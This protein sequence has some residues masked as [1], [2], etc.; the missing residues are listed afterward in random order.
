MLTAFLESRPCL[1]EAVKKKKKKKRN[2]YR[3]GTASFFPAPLI[4]A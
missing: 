2:P 1:H 4:S 3:K